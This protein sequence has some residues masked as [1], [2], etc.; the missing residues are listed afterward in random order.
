MTLVLK[1]STSID[2]R[3]GPFVD[4]TDGVTPETVVSLGSADQAE[5]LKANGATTAAMGGAFAAVSGCDGWYN[6]TVAAGD[7][8]T[9]G[10]V[11]F[12]VQDSDLCLPVFTRA[13][14]VEENVYVAWYAASAAAGTDLASILTDTGTTLDGKLDTID[15]F[16]D[17]E[18]AAITAAVIT[19]AAG[20]DVA[21]DIIAL[22]AETA[23][24][25]ADTNELQTDWANSGRLDALVD[26]I[27]AETVLIVEDTGTTVPALIATLDAVVDT[28]KAETVLILADTNELQGDN[29]PASLT[30][31]SNKVDVI[32]AIVDIIVIDTGTTLDTKIN[33]IDTV[34]DAI[35]VKT[36]SLTFTSGTDLDAN[37]QKVNDVAVG[38]TGASGSEWGPA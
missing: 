35:K 17:T 26:S 30:T 9:V 18:I 22:K 34:V 5:V 27:K 16:L 37:I 7:V 13:T 1:Q 21:A 24:I 31:L 25:V 4:A 28:V 29:I 3:I 38:G 23:T 36:D 33:T 10:E 8:D 19:N 12:V 11:V 32:D 6:Y 20:V 2:I 15:D 14:V